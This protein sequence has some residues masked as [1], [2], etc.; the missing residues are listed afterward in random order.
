MNI[1]I[2]NKDSKYIKVG[3]RNNLKYNK[4]ANI[5]N[6]LD[7]DIV[8]FNISNHQ[9][10]LVKRSGN[11]TRIISFCGSQDINP[12][13]LHVSS[14]STFHYPAIKMGIAGV[15]QFQEN[16][17]KIKGKSIKNTPELEFKIDRKNKDIGLCL[18]EN[19]DQIGFIHYE[20]LDHLYDD[21]EKNP[22]DFRVKLTKIIKFDRMNYVGLRADLFYTGNDK[23][24]FKKKFEEITED[25]E[26]KPII[27]PKIKPESPE[28]I[29]KLIL[30]HDEKLHG[31]EAAKNVKI[32]I[33][34]IV[35]EIKKDSNKNILLLG[36]LSPDGDSIGC[37]LAMK[38]AIELMKSDKNVDCAVDDRIVNL[39]SFLP[40]I[41]DI[42]SPSVNQLISNVEERINELKSNDSN[43]YEVEV[44]T[45]VKYELKNSLK[46]LD[47]D[48]KY[49]LVILMDI[50]DPERLGFNFSKFIDKEKT[51]IIFI[52]HHPKRFKNWDKYK[53]K[54]NI[55]INKVIDRK[56]LL[57]EDKVPAAVELV[58]AIIGKLI[59]WINE[60]AIDISSCD[61][62]I[63]DM[64]KAVLTGLQTD[65]G[66]YA[67][68]ANLSNEDKM[69]PRWER[70]KYDPMGLA[71]WF[72]AKTDHSVT[73]NYIEANFERHDAFVKVFENQIAKIT[74]D[75]EYNKNLGLGC[76]KVP[77]DDIYRL[78]LNMA[79][80]NPEI[81][82]SDVYGALK[83][84]RTMRKLKKKLLPD[85]PNYSEYEKSK[86]VYLIYQTA[87]RGEMNLSLKKSKVDKLSFSFR[88]AQGTNYAALLGELFGGGGHGAAA[89]GRIS[90]QKLDFDTKLLVKIDGKIVNDPS[91]ILSA[92]ENNFAVNTSSM[93]EK[94]KLQMLK[95]VEVI[96]SPAQKYGRT[97]AEL[98]EDV[99][100]EIRIR[101]DIKDTNIIKLN[102]LVKVKNS[103]F[104]LST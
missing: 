65:T 25:E 12:V 39:F 28:D 3:N 95:N 104:V 48:K 76:V 73:R 58:T 56:L 55:D 6:N 90:A 4:S 40:G 32:A 78:W 63:S 15:S 86:I 66:G 38:N 101:Q 19:S 102:Q 46:P 2:N 31:V 93:Q 97:S 50:A 18:K 5:L 71:K 44:L 80:K 29:L 67:R 69:L 37:V 84:S 100:K 60:P 10:A 30:K 8:Q 70:P 99:V 103:K 36:H 9:G 1:F 21:I 14:L 23:D 85:N 81:M 47:Q 13:D 20:V 17:L 52:D 87:K 27:F 91:Q 62:Q 42:K 16:I 43:S 64:A 26:C 94:K 59:P 82:E 96:V 45:R 79:D 77:F 11:I 57:V 98:V 51:N 49:D 22:Q 74:S 35:E 41:K 83:Y 34:T 68:A 92:L 53:N 54:T 61:R 75:S 89:G 88:S 33:N 72:A 24:K 7:K